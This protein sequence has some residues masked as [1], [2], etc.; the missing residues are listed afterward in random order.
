MRINCTIS[1]NV[2]VPETHSEAR[3]T[4]EQLVHDECELLY[5]QCSAFSKYPVEISVILTDDDTGE[6]KIE[7]FGASNE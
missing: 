6:R 2:D 5:T 3:Q 1:L 4:F 7:L